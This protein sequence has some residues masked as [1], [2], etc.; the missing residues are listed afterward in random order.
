M[1]EPAQQMTYAQ[2][3]A[4]GFAQGGAQ[5]PASAAVPPQMP[6]AA[7]PQGKPAAAAQRQKKAKQPEQ[8]LD[9]SQLLKKKD[10]RH[11]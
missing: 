11:L 1:S 6:T 9:T 4:D 3:P 10:D 8:I 7:Q 5:Q 2:M